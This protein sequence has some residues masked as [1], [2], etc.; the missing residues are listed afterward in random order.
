MPMGMR[1]EECR[2]TLYL[3]DLAGCERAAHTQVKI[4]I[5]HNMLRYIDSH[6]GRPYTFQKKAEYVQVF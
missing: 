4:H 3:T 6:Q 5:H 1:T 2:S